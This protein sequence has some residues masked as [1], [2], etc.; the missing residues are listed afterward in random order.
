MT[1][2]SRCTVAKI[3]TVTKSESSQRCLGR[4]CR[5]RGRAIDDYI[6]DH[7]R[8]HNDDEDD[9]KRKLF[10]EARSEVETPRDIHKHDMRFIRSRQVF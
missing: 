6:D 1:I 7:R 3:A 4:G 2:R 8:Y 5:E 9:M 10:L